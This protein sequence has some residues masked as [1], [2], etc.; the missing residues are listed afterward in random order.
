MPSPLVARPDAG[1]A[2]PPDP[3]R[4]D[5]T[6]NARQT[7]SYG[8]PSSMGSSNG[9]APRSFDFLMCDSTVPRF[10]RTVDRGE[11]SPAVLAGETSGGST[12]RRVVLPVS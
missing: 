12:A 5:P 4:P 10:F 9:T 1:P 11:Q 3:T 2:T 8:Q 6:R 7:C